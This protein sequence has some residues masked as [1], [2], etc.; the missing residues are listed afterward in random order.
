MSC[1]QLVD[2]Y[3]RY[4]INRVSLDSDAEDQCFQ[5]LY[6]FLELLTHV[7]SKELLDLSSDGNKL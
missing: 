6:I 2:V 4:N 3:A 5:D 1:F 7:M